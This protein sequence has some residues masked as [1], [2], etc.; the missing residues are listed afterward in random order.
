MRKQ[1]IILSIFLSL[2]TPIFAQTSQTNDAE[3]IPQRKDKEDEKLRLIYQVFIYSGDVKNAFKTAKIALKRR[4]HSLY[5]HYKMAEVA[6]WLGKGSW[7]LESMNYIYQHTHSQKMKKKILSSALQLYQYKIAAPLIKEETMKNPT[8]KNIKDLIFVYNK[9]GRPEL[10]AKYLEKLAKMKGEDEDLLRETLKIYIL[11]GENEKAKKIIEKLKKK[12]HLKIETAREISFYYIPKKKLKEAYKFLLRA[13]KN[14][15]KNKDYLIQVSDLGWYLKDF[16]PSVKASKRLIDLKKARVIDYERVIL[17]Y[18][19]KNPKIVEKVALEAYKKSKKT[20][21]F[22]TY[23]SMLQA[24]KKYKKLYKAFK[25]LEKDPNLFKNYKNDPSYYLMKAETFKALGL[26]DKAEKAY[27][28]AIKLNPSSSEIKLALFW[29]YIDSKNIPKLK[30]EIFKIEDNL[31][32]DKSYYLPLAM[33]HYFLN[34]VDKAIYYIQKVRREKR[35]LEN[36]MTY[37]YLLQLRGNDRAFMQI[38][39]RIFE[40]LDKKVTPKNLKNRDFL[41]KYL[42]TGIYFLPPERFEKLLFNSK[43]ILGKKKYE[44]LKIAWAQKNNA[45]ERLKFISTKLSEPRVWVDLSVA[46]AENDYS[47]AQKLLYKYYM[48]LPPLDTALAAKKS[49]NISFAHT[50]LFDA[51]EKN[52]KNE[53]IYQTRKDLIENYSNKLQINSTFSRSKSKNKAEDFEIR[54]SH[55]IGRGFY[56][57]NNAGIQKEYNQKNSKWIESGF[58]KIFD[59]GSFE[60]LGGFRSEDKNYF[61]LLLNGNYQATQNLNLQSN[62]EVNNKANEVLGG[63]VKDKVELQSYYQILPSIFFHLSGGYEKFYT[64]N[65]NKVGSGMKAKAEISKEFF[66]KYPNLKGSIFI[67]YENFNKKNVLPNDYLKLGS[68]ISFGTLTKDSFSRVWK[69]YFEVTPYYEFFL[70]EL[71]LS[72]DAG[73]GGVVFGR[74]KLRFDLNYNQNI[75]GEK[76]FDY[77]VGVDYQLFY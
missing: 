14:S 66:K 43:K 74:D 40:H 56:L 73:Y 35:S 72:L 18:G 48:I 36:D 12:P 7:A 63:G 61:Y 8:Q 16:L 22:S 37:A 9:I 44:D 25:F 10:A 6:S 62:L 52:S 41:S 23:M 28:K 65:R 59:R 70:N 31:K 13:W 51:R 3:L 57:K 5:W 53:S 27:K 76:K 58:E 15:T 60:I 68:T 33:A 1:I 20:Y 32:I 4:P 39:R 45:T 71:D 29:F 11:L 38:F 49:G 24:Q 26:F 77:G 30:E 75:I 64:K 69:G 2:F 54:N 47:K 19:D 21:L 55:Y 34:D 46:L 17:F 42:E 67:D 50:I